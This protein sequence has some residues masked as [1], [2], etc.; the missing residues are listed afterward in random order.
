MVEYRMEEFLRTVAFT[1]NLK[2]IALTR[3][4]HL[5]CRYI[6]FYVIVSDDAFA[7]SK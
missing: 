4:N 7:F 1:E 6:L 2:E 5:N 3:L